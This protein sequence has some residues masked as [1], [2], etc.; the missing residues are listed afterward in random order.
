[1]ASFQAFLEIFNCWT[2]RVS[3]EPSNRDFLLFFFSFFFFPS[4]RGNR[5]R[6]EESK[7][8]SSAPCD[9]GGERKAARSGIGLRW[10]RRGEGLEGAPRGRRGKMW[11]K[12]QED[13]R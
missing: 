5:V 12:E 3:G 11:M 7:S 2:V 9:S 10:A 6:E 4:G 13:E 8:S 1:M